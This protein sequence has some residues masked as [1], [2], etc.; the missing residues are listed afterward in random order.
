MR[1]LAAILVETARPLVLAELEVPPP[2]PGQVL[3]E[4]AYAAVCHT[5]LLEVR[6]H[7][8]PDPY[9]PHCLGHEGSGR[10]RT[11]GPQVRKVAS[12]DPVLLSWMRGSGAEVPGTSY[13]WGGRRVNAGGIATFGRL[14]LISENR[15]T[16]LPAG[17]PLRDAALFGCAVPT[18]AGAV[19]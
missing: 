19:L 2:G 7:R 1:T 10:V 12:G 3:V 16:V 4:V 15:L 9:L 14:M 6:G 11:T 5:Q 13:S 17:F 8:G 18:G